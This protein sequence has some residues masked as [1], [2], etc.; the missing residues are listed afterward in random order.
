[1]QADDEVQSP[2]SESS[3]D[4]DSDSHSDAEDPD[5]RIDYQV[6]HSDANHKQS[7]EGDVEVAP[8]ENWTEFALAAFVD[9]TDLSRA[10][11]RYLL[12]LVTVRSL[13]MHIS[14]TAHLHLINSM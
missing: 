11:A 4:S 8:F 5:A 12:K 2:D 10:E 14:C 9:S 3:S 7:K 1:M 13:N 6:L